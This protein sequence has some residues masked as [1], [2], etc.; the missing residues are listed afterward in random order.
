ETL[1]EQDLRL[2]KE[3][4]R[5]AFRQL[6]RDC[7]G[8]RRVRV[9]EERRARAQVIVE[10]LAPRYIPDAASFA[11]GDDEIELRRKDE[12]AETAACEELTRGGK[13]DGLAFGCVHE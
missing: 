1:R 8:D 6:R 3:V 4:V 11:A 2:V 7:L 12:T 10:I 9:T 13:E 5:R